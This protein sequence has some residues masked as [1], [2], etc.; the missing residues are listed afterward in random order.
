M[1]AIIQRHMSQKSTNLDLQ[2]Q[3]QIYDAVLKA[4]DG[5]EEAPL[6]QQM[7]SLRL[8]GNASE[9]RLLGIAAT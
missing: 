8:A 4:E 9:M 5:D 3:F 7:D 1:E 2:E 6:L